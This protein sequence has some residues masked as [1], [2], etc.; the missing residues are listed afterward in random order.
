MLKWNILQKL[1]EISDCKLEGGND[2][3]LSCI[4]TDTKPHGS[5]TCLEA[6][7]LLVYPWPLLKGHQQR[8]I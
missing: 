7:C 8:T 6:A 3:E 5:D 4:G 2:V 1:L